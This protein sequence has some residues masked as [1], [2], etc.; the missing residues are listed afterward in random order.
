M[1]MRP[2]PTSAGRPALDGGRRRPS[3]GRAW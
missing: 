3:A 2:P 1:V